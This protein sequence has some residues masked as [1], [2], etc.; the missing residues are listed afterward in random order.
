MNIFYLIKKT[1]NEITALNKPSGLEIKIVSVKA[2]SAEAFLLSNLSS[3][4][5]LKNIKNGVLLF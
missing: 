1:A 2:S 4:N 3:H 5:F